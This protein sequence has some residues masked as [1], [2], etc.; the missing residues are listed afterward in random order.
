MRSAART[1]AVSAPALVVVAIAWLRLEQPVGSLWPVLALLALA[2][3]AAIP[4]Q[5]W[6]RVLG[7]VAATVLA[8]RVAVDVDLVPWRL[9]QPSSGFGLADSFSTLGTRFGN[10]FSDFYGTHLPFDPRVHVAM[11]ELVLSGL[12]LFALGVA[13]LAAARKPVASALTLLVGAG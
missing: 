6:L 11:N 1:V 10:G 12:F 4:T 13:L 2:L 8:A 3:A 9:N 5:R 7:T